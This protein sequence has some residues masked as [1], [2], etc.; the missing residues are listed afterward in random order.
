MGALGNATVYYP[1]DN[2]PNHGG[3]P[4]R[5]SSGVTTP[6]YAGDV[7]WRT[8][9]PPTPDA[10]SGGAQDVPA[11]M[12]FLPDG[13]LVE[14]GAMGGAVE[15]DS[16]LGVFGWVGLL[17]LVVLGTAIG[18]VVA[19]RRI[20]PAERVARERREAAER[21]ARRL[22]EEAERLRREAAEPR[23]VPVKARY[24]R[25]SRERRREEVPEEEMEYIPPKR[26]YQ[27]AVYER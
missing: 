2:D 6:A 9:H 10:E 16:G 20:S 7:V 19:Y 15:G 17:G 26:R 5:R 12:K 23:F 24:A 27:T 3:G 18:T 25:V 8:P 11:G 13:R 21:Q 4:I 14:A 22:T 1:P